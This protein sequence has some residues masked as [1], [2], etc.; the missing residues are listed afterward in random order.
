MRRTHRTRSVVNT[1][2]AHLGTVGT[3]Y[4]GTYPLPHREAD[5]G[6]YL[7]RTYCVPTYLPQ[8]NLAELIGE[9]GGRVAVVIRAFF[10]VTFRL[11][12]SHLR[13]IDQ[14]ISD[15]SGSVSRSFE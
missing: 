12:M 2:V 3:P 11:A 1:C 8:E 4:R 10:S 14:L 15:V 7:P 9:R 5:V 13:L 6:T